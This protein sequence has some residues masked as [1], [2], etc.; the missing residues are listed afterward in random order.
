M[1]SK[2]IYL[3]CFFCVMVIITENKFFGVILSAR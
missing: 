1:K 3:S 2:I